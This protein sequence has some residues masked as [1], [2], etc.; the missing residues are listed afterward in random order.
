MS[1]VK[2]KGEKKNPAVV[3]TPKKSKE[4]KEE[5]KVKESPKLWAYSGPTLTR[6]PTCRTLFINNVTMDILTDSIL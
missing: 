3:D 2:K 5:R 6:G 1:K 4:N